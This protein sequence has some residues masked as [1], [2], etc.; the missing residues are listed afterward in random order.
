M[1]VDIGRSRVY[2]G[3]HY[4]Y[5]CVEGKKQGQRIVTNVLN[6]LKFKKE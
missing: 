3:I 4:T 1:A 2:A 6:I 5:S